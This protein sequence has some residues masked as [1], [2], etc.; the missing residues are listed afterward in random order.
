MISLINRLYR[1]ALFRLY[2]NT[3]LVIGISI[4]VLYFGGLVCM[5]AFS[6]QAIVENY[7]WWF[8]VT[9]TTVGYGDFAPS[10]TEGRLVAGVVMILGIGIIGLVIGK[11]AENIIEITNRKA[12]GLSKM[13]YENHTIIMGYCKGSTEKM[14]TEL[15]VDNAEQKI[16]LCSGSQ[17]Y[18]PL[19]KQKVE[20]IQGDL[21]SLDVLKRSNAAYAQKII[22]QGRDDDQTFFTAYALREVNTHAHMV[23]CLMDEGHVGK[24]KRL[25]ADDPAMNQ[26][27]LPANI[28]LMAQEIQDRESSAVI[29]DLISNLSGENMYRLDLTHDKDFELSY[30]SLFFNLKQKVGVTLIAVKDKKMIINPPLDF[31]VRSGMALFY[32]G[33][34]RLTE[35]DLSSFGEMV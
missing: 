14:V 31:I 23:C 21:A 7:S 9:I 12:K 17:D 28:Y 6:E 4:A 5:I 26:V 18:N 32:A 34:K 20:F 15:L 27:V 35:L 25:P 22:V 11:L 1:R 33:P 16:V 3:W 19:L 8:I 30:E 13:N 10:G 29:Q 2:E 24:I